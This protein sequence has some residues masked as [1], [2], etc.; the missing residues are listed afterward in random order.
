MRDLGIA[1]AGVAIEPGFVLVGAS[2]D[3]FLFVQGA[4]YGH[5]NVGGVPGAADDVEGAS[6]HRFKVQLPLAGAGR[7]DDA[8][9]LVFV[10]VGVDEVREPAVGKMLVAKHHFKRLM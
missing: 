6:A 8:G 1:V 3:G 9:N 5:F 10:M 2:G 7:D 4:D